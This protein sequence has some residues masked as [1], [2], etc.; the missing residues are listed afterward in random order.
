MD[1]FYRFLL[2]V[3]LLGMAYACGK[4]WEYCFEM[5]THSKFWCWILSCSV[6]HEIGGGWCLRCGKDH[7]FNKGLGN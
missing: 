3:G 5:H 7:D 1:T 4:A 2:I 6:C